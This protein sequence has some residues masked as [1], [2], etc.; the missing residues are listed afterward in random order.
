M[1]EPLPTPLKSLRTYPLLANTTNKEEIQLQK[2]SCWGEWLG[3]TL[4]GRVGEES[5]GGV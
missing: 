2:K 1:N 4:R 3:N 5:M